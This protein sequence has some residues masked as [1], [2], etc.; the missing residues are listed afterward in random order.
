MERRKKEKSEKR[1][2]EESGGKMGGDR[3]ANQ[4]R[5][6]LRPCQEQA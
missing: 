6:R 5:G 2:K 1:E 3:R 4:G